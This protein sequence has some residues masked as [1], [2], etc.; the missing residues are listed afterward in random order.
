LNQLDVAAT[1]AATAAGLRVQVEELDSS[2]RPKWHALLGPVRL[3]R[4]GLQ[5]VSPRP[6]RLKFTF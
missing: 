3:T 4:D 1:S 5:A 2:T 6:L